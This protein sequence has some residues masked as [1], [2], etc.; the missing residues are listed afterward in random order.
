M[1]YQGK[2]TKPS[3]GNSVMRAAFV[4][5]CLLLASTCMMA[6]LL[7]KYKTSSPG[8]DKGSVAKFEVNV[9]GNAIDTQIVCTPDPDTGRY[10]VTVENLSE[11][12]VRYDLSLTFTSG[13]TTGVS[14]SFS[15]ASGDLAVGAV[16]TS[17]LTIS[18]D[19]EQFTADKIG[20]EATVD[21]GFIVTVN[22]AQ[23]D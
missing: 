5:L 3:S 9:E 8:D 11:V 17:T 23:I 19:W 10:T 1:A 20:S 2:Y 16:G 12:A 7:A 22:V 18:V 4:L 6:G 13:N 21:L 14:Y 15:P